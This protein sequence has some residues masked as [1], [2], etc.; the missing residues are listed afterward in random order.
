MTNNLIKDILYSLIKEINETTEYF[1]SIVSVEH[2][3]SYYVITRTNEDFKTV[4]IYDSFE[5]TLDYYKNELV[6]I[7]NAINHYINNYANK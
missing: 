7:S 4:K 1:I 2:I 6:S 5:D 3:G